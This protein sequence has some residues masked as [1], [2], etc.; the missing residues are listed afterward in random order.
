MK[1]LI[2]ICAFGFAVVLV[3]L[4]TGQ[5]RT[6]AHRDD[7]T[8]LASYNPS[9][10][11]RTINI[12]GPLD[13]DNPFFK[14]LG[15]NGRS[16]FSC[17][18]P[19]QGWTI[20]PESVQE[21]FKESRGLDP[22][23]RTNDGSNCEVT[24]VSTLR[25]RRAAY[26]L[27]LNR[28]LIRI[29]IEVPAGAEFV[30]ESVDDP[31][32]CGAP[33]T[34]AS[35]Y[36]RPLPSTNLP[37]L[38]AVMWDGR[39]S[40]SATT[41]LQDLAKQADDATMGHAQASFHLTPQQA[42]AIVAFETGLFT[43]QSHDNDAGQLRA[44]GAMGGPV[45]LSRQPFFIGINDP[46][47]LNPTGAPFDP[48]AFTIFREWATR[49]A[50]SRRNAI[51][52]ARMAIARGQ[53]IFNTKP[54]VITGVAGLNNQTFS[55]GVTVPDPFTAGKHL[56]YRLYREEQL[57]L[58][59]KR[60]KRRKM[61]VARRER[62]QARRPNEAWALD[63][64]A[65][66]LVSGCRF[67]ALT[68]VDVFSP[69]ALAIAVGQRLGA[70]NVVD[71]LNRLVAQR[72]APKVI[73]ADNGGEFTGRLLDL[74]AYHHKVQ[75]D[76]RRP[77]KP[78]DNSF[79]ESFN[80]SLRDECLNVNW[81]ESM[82]DAKQSIEAW[83]VEYNESRPHM[84]LAGLGRSDEDHNRRKPM[85]RLVRRTEALHNRRKLTINLDR[86]RGALQVL[87][88]PMNYRSGLQGTKLKWLLRSRCQVG[89]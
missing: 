23:F 88:A 63:F 61:V 48:R 4:M 75:I 7:T 8:Q 10:V 27:L 60:P 73:F 6:L 34:G 30:I 59:C 74:W 26:S 36:R 76:F 17:H 51:D 84:G 45:A 85:L 2:K 82:D 71:A 56:V 29:G 86:R 70:D 53:E 62:L 49:S 66:Q 19:A 13:L 79:V 22:I 72:R 57:Q 46:V 64:V 32:N 47:G 83:R 25:K 89:S 80:G 67:R 11:V 81:F 20:T 12:N 5:Q 77:G 3:G 33:L 39:E 78:T 44:G 58:R 41:V 28:G 1:Q 50:E 65:D 9:G 38:S 35:M 43:A 24:D 42:Q 21:R 14:A 54:I 52:R 31:Y 68:I 15:T 87:I 69:E 55:N 37:F 18:R 16:C 40:S